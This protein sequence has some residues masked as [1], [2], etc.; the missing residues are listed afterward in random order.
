MR[1]AYIMGHFPVISETF[2]LNQIAG[3]RDRGNEVDILALKG[4]PKESTDKTH[5]IVEKYQLLDRTYYPPKGAEVS[6][7]FVEKT[8]ASM[9]VD[10]K[11]YDIIHCQ[12]GQHGI[13]MMRLRQAGLI[14]GKILTNFRGNDISKYLQK[15]GNDVYNELFKEGDYFLANCEFF[16]QRAIKI[17][18]PSDKISVH[19][20]GIDCKRF[21]FTPRYLPA[22]G[23]IKV[24]TTGRFVEKKGIEY[25][26]RAIA[27]S[28]QKHPSLEYHLIGDGPLREKFENL[29]E[30]LEI[31]P[32]VILHGWKEQREIVEILDNCQLFV[33]SSVTA[34]DGNQ[35]APVNTLKEAMAM[36]LP[37]IGTL[38]GG[39][40]ELVEEGISGF[41]VPERDP[42]AI[43]AK[44]SYL[45]EHP[46]EWPQ[47]GKAGRERVKEKYDMNRLNQELYELYQKLARS[48][49]LIG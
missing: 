39:I 9:F 30:E 14:Q 24:A 4:T 3:A 35:D 34:A 32:F 37:V 49:Q 26:I 25:A 12:F 22:D 33:A 41:L 21:S 47:M 38:H 5:P 13:H 7:K 29:I 15:R 10:K 31:K 6:T 48:E 20:S 18:C 36:G 1:I 40:P 42:E 45:I 23:V 43:A 17:G 11:P 44:L 8:H 46:E 27:L 16:R 19:G 2:I 28:V